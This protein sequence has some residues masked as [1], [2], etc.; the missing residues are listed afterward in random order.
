MSANGGG[1]QGLLGS[2]LGGINPQQQQ[3]QQ[4]QSQQSQSKFTLFSN[5]CTI[6]N[7]PKKIKLL[8]LLASTF[9]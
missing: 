2:L 9:Q 7:S 3:Q 8:R 6:P 5:E 4:Q 1:L